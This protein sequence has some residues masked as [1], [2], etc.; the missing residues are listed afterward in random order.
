[1]SKQTNN[2]ETNQT[3][4]SDAP[5]ASEN[6]TVD[7]PTT[8]KVEQED[9]AAAEGAT[10]E[11]DGQGEEEKEK[12]EGERRQRLHT[13]GSQRKRFKWFISQGYD[14]DEAS[15]LAK[16]AL[17]YRELRAAAEGRSLE[18]SE[19]DKKLAEQ[20]KALN[21]IAKRKY[22]QLL[23]HGYSEEEAV[24]LA[25]KLADGADIR[26]KHLRSDDSRKPGDPVRIIIAVAD[27]PRTVLTE[28]QSK[29]VKEAILKLV[30]NET[31]SKTK[32]HFAG[33]N[34]IKGY[35]VFE[36]QDQQTITWV[37]HRAR[38]LQLWEGCVLRAVSEK[39][40]K[41]PDYFTVQLPDSEQDSN[42]DISGFLNKQN[43]GIDT[44]KWIIA[45]RKLDEKTK[46]VE[47]QIKIDP[48]S[49]KAIHEL[50]YKLNY[51]FEEI[52][53]K[54]MTVDLFGTD[55]KP[56]RSTYNNPPRRPFRGGGYSGGPPNRYGGR[57][58]GYNYNY[59]NRPNNVMDSLYE[60]MN[61]NLAFERQVRPNNNFGGGGNQY[62]RRGPFQGGGGNGVGDYVD[63]LL[64]QLNRSLYPSQNNGPFNPSPY[65]G[66]GRGRGGWNRNFPRQQR[67]F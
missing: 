24:A 14:Q 11:V 13:C 51:K 29:L 7:D 23:E 4:G 16:N 56:K 22:T 3:E 18:V 30:G 37:Q 35:L 63:C 43:D 67:F 66:G 45:E 33:C 50:N 19:R 48:M 32:P 5:Q 39:T 21:R 28:D 25:P 34:F 62:N 40:L 52:T 12:P 65:G 1:M 53:L 49:A 47:L 38:E 10:M 64:D 20:R 17:K 8:I 26:Q 9:D 15:D 27:Y 44:S 58:P 60:Q 31:V 41:T 61:R 54:R 46:S 6:Q 59:N 36:C 42:E 55:S 57:P 2:Q